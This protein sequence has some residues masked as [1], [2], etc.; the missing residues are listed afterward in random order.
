MKDN[1]FV[2]IFKRVERMWGV[3]EKDEEAER[4]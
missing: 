2:A 1:R 4:Q 3:R